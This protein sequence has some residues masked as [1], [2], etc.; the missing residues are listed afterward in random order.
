MS[1]IIMWK[2]LFYILRSFFIV[3]TISI[4]H[5]EN[6][7]VYLSTDNL[8]FPLLL[9]VIH[10]HYFGTQIK[11]SLCT[12][13]F[14]WQNS[15]V[16]HYPPKIRDQLYLLEWPEQIAAIHSIKSSQ[17]NAA[18]VILNRTD[19]IIRGRCGTTIFIF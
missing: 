10:V 15:E 4:D 1:G 17:L 13:A 16:L 5:F 12:M 6:Y 9:E 11:P 3:Y 2:T 8:L 18:N 19:Q 14:S 7:F